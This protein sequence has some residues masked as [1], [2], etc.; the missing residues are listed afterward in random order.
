MQVITDSIGYAEK[1]LERELN[2]KKDPGS[3]G[4]LEIA[5]IG[6]SLFGDKRLFWC[7]VESGPLW[8]YLF[9]AETSPESQYDALV[10]LARQKVKL[11]DGLL[12]MAATGSGFHGFK[13]R[14]WKSLAGNIHLSV[15][16]S[17]D[18]V[19]AHIGGSF[20]ALPAVS[21]IQTLDTIKG[22][23]NRATVKWVND[24][25]VEDAKVCGV[26]AHSQTIG[27]TV[28]GVVLGIGLN[29]GATPEIEPDGFVSR[30]ASLHS[31][32]RDKDVCRQGL[33]FKRLIRMLEK[34]YFSLLNGGESVLMDFYRERSCITG[35]DVTICF[36]DKCREVIS[37]K[38][39]GIGDNLE[40][41]LEGVEKPVTKGRLMFHPNGDEG[42]R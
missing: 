7:G 18:R 11:P 12:C 14:P 9:V 36:D 25:L 15:F 8:Q 31:F 22:L 2:W 24:I 27:K 39:C 33:V 3:E 40:L 17:P 37:G 19:I 38:V 10:R 1:L 30:A 32:V 6:R 34:N 21:V 41:Y 5:V 29:V 16:L 35:R 28:T 26:L 20:M 13:K 4:S 23:E 42:L